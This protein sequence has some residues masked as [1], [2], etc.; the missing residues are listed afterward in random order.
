M[1]QGK[2]S[3][4]YTK[5]NLVTRG[6]HPFRRP[7]THLLLS[8]LMVSSGLFKALTTLKI[9]ILIA[10]FGYTWSDSSVYWVD[11]L[12]NPTRMLACNAEGS[13]PPFYFHMHAN[14]DRA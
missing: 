9:N 10:G 13:G 14:F 7:T 6:P 11:L 3:L 12:R 5:F 2:I 4:N 1:K 8:D